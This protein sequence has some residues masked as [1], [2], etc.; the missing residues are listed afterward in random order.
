MANQTWTKTT[1]GNVLDTLGNIVGSGNGAGTITITSATVQVSNGNT[2][3]IEQ[4]VTVKMNSATG[5]FLVTRNATGSGHLVVAGIESE[6]VTITS[7]QAVPA[8]ADW[9]WIELLNT[10]AASNP[11]VVADWMILE[12]AS[13]GVISVSGSQKCDVTLTH[14][15]LRRIQDSYLQTAG[16]PS[17][18]WLATS[19]VFDRCTGDGVTTNDLIIC[20]GA[21]TGP[22]MTIDHCS[23]SDRVTLATFDP[24]V[25]Q[26]G[27]R[28]TLIVRN[29]IIG[30][31]NTSAIRPLNLLVVSAPGGACTHDWNWQH[32]LDQSLGEQWVN[33]AHDQTRDP[34][35]FD[36]S[37]STAHQDLRPRFDTG[38]STADEFGGLLGA[39]EPYGVPVP[40]SPEPEAPCNAAYG[41]FIDPTCTPLVCDYDFFTGDYPEDW[42]RELIDRRNVPPHQLVVC[43][44]LPNRGIDPNFTF[45]PGVPI[46]IID[47]SS[48]TVTVDIGC[49]VQQMRPLRT[50]R[51][52]TFQEYQGS[53]VDLVV[54]DWFGRL[55]P[56]IQ[57]SLF[58]NLRWV[59]LRVDVGSWIQGTAGV[60][61]HGRFFIRDIKRRG[62]NTV[63][64][65]GDWFL[66]TLS[67]PLRANAIPL[68]SVSF[69]SENP[70]VSF[71]SQFVQ[72]D[73]NFATVETVRL[74]IQD[75]GGD[76]S[77]TYKYI[78]SVSGDQGTGSF[79][80][81]FTTSDGAVTITQ[82]VWAATASAQ[83][84]FAPG[85]EVRF[86]LSNIL[87]G[88]PVALAYEYLTTFGTLVE[89][90]DIVQSQFFEAEAI[91]PTNA[92]VQ[93]RFDAPVTLLEACRVAARHGV[94]TFSSNA[95]GHVVLGGFKPTLAL[96]LV[97]LQNVAIC[98][99][100]DLG[101]AETENLPV[102]NVIRGSYNPVEDSDE[103]T[104]TGLVSKEG[105]R[106]LSYPTPDLGPDFNRSLQFWGVPYPFDLELPGFRAG[107]EAAVFAVLQTLWVLFEGTPTAREKLTLTT[108]LA[109]LNRDL[110]D[111]V[112]V[113]SLH[114]RREIW[115]QVIGYG[116][117][118]LKQSIELTVVDMSDIV[119]P[120]FACGYAFCDVG[121]RT[122]D[123]W[124]CW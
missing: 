41:R 79:D 115:A 74:I 14:C 66:E 70:N 76:T 96:D 67:A 17:G 71:P 103:T 101:D 46:P 120:D 38:V 85:D 82:K 35:F 69:K 9:H 42:Q 44:E 29:S 73:T 47:I 110:E 91:L 118:P 113:D 117:D 16:I 99:G 89:G 92:S 94:L 15:T 83:G 107:Q 8:A 78:G 102:F 40:P 108:N 3:R 43:I 63:M 36:T 86:T 75:E 32:L 27:V 4:G 39:L 97:A 123:C 2:L 112:R 31:E 26:A 93:L 80:A 87:I 24:E 45:A 105:T 33:A 51:D 81:T 7:G 59:G 6:P 119:Q 34:H 23:I 114:P 11:T 62:E 28:G 57:G 111:I 19:C 116:K 98:S 50:E 30:G 49:W 37:C 60:L 18:T 13:S 64:R 5:R 100:M 22:T 52:V 122:D 104:H 61:R 65:L 25:F 1:S 12:Y 109:N 77:R 20:A 48:D 88:T 72:I 54:M 55:D 124:V 10:D 21:G 68:D 106:L 56:K 95:E 53:D 121:H 84:V 90:V 58:Y